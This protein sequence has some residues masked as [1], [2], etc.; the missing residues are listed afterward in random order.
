MDVW[1]APVQAR[2]EDAR[3]FRLR[4]GYAEATV[5]AAPF[6]VG[7]LDSRDRGPSFSSDGLSLFFCSDARGNMDL[8]VTTRASTSD[9]WQEP[10]ALDALNTA[11]DEAFPAVSSDGLTLFLSDWFLFT[12]N[13]RSDGFGA[14]DLWVSTRTSLQ[15]A[16]PPPINLGVVVNSE[17]AEGTPTI[18]RDGLTLI[19]A[20]DR[21]EDANAG[22]VLASQGL[23]SQG[24]LASQGQPLN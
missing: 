3:M 12:P 11:A 20:S 13:L 7:N 21:S 10:V 14:G 5:V 6:P 4:Q 16:W 1:Q 8:W 9:A 22:T 17:F 2:L 19:F 24:H 18:S 15:E 23:A